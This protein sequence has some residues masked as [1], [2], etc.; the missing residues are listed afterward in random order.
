[1]GLALFAKGATAQI[2][3]ALFVAISPENDIALK[4]PRFSVCG[5]TYVSGRTASFGY[6][7]GFFAFQV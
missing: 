1:M 7:A 2:A 6:G 3:V 5:V 4:T